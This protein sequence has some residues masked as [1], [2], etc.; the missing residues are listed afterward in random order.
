[1]LQR[2][3]LGCI[4]C[5]MGPWRFGSGPVSDGR[6][7]ALSGGSSGLGE[8][9]QDCGADIASQEDGDR[10]VANGKRCSSAKSSAASAVEWDLGASAAALSAMA[11]PQRCQA[12]AQDWASNIRTAELTLPARKTAIGW[13]PT[14]S[15]A[16]ARRARL[17]QLS[18]GTLALRQRPCQRWQGRSA[19]R[20]KLRTGRATSG[21]RS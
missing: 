5:R 7:A 18:N 11:G 19:V 9:H 10:V 14:E 1:M 17:H 13:W 12:E 20:R 3:E 6:A 15:D 4:S 2:E 21:L 8:Q 16:P